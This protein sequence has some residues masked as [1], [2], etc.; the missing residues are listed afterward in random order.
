M[1]CQKAKGKWSI[2]WDE[3]GVSKKG[4]RVFSVV[5]NGLH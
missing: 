5:C 2:T 4:F 3:L 1:P